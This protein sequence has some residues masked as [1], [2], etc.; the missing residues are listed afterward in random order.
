MLVEAKSKSK[1]DLRA[2]LEAERD[3][4]RKEIAGRE[5]STEEEHAG[6]G[7]HMADDATTVFEQA[8][9]VGLKRDEELMLADAEEA[10]KRM[11]EGSYGICRRCGQAIDMARLRVL[12]TAALCL[13]CQEIVESR[14]P[15]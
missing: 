15:R 4:L 13:S 12:P 11:D 14:E 3:R 10:L 2:Y 9:S 1:A 6:Y 8:M 5:T 7:N